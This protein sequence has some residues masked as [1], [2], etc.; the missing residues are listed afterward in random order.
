MPRAGR[1]HTAE[2]HEKHRYY[3]HP[4][5][6]RLPEHLRVFYNPAPRLENGRADI[7]PK[8]VLV[9]RW[10]HDDREAI[11]RYKQLK[12]QMSNKTGTTTAPA[13]WA[14]VRDRA[15][16]HH[17]FVAS[18]KQPVATAA[19]ASTAL[20]KPAALKVRY[21]TYKGVPRAKYVDGQINLPDA[22]FV[23]A[24]R[25]YLPAKE[26]STLDNDMKEW[27]DLDNVVTIDLLQ[28]MD[29]DEKR[30]V[31]AKAVMTL[32]HKYAPIA[33]R[34]EIERTMMLDTPA[35]KVDRKGRR[36]YYS[37][38]D[39]AG[40][41]PK[42]TLGYPD[43]KPVSFNFCDSDSEEDLNPP[44]A[45]YHPQDYPFLDSHRIL[46]LQDWIMWT[47][48]NCTPDLLSQWL[49]WFTENF[50]TAFTKTFKDFKVNDTKM[51]EVR[52]AFDL[53]KENCQ[54]G[55]KRLVTGL[56]ELAQSEE[57]RHRECK[58][59]A[60]P[61]DTKGK[62]KAS[63]EHIDSHEFS[64]FIS[65]ANQKFETFSKEINNY[66]MELDKCQAIKERGDIHKHEE[67]KK[68]NGALLPAEHDIRTVILRF[69]WPE[70]FADDAGLLADS[71]KESSVP[72]PDSSTG[73]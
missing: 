20:S 6:P 52:D 44:P 22:A 71:E 72:V 30:K 70:E 31:L 37:V 46:H 14:H 57:V 45:A 27:K 1:D 51:Q 12:E 43:N 48:K 56:Y 41:E 61:A 50:D 36:V 53:H 38:V 10:D 33:S 59:Q 55:V 19:D 16:R 13:Y 34:A 28:K 24:I 8:D 40:Y 39:R 65:K 62:K 15:T 67:F 11:Q 66:I 63:K 32:C 18:E 29:L 68:F 42:K 58:N 17:H 4:D 64:S 9:E 69:A 25:P 5:N 49:K 35:P 60:A 7:P 23:E 21:Q 26:L 73:M 54:A 47:L 3:D 2:E